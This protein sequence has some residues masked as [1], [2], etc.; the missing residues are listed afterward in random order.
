MMLYPGAPSRWQFTF[1]MLY[2]HAAKLLRLVSAAAILASPILPGGTMWSL[3]SL[4]L[5]AL[6]IVMS[7]FFGLW[8][9]REEDK[10]PYVSAPRP[11]RDCRTTLAETRFIRFHQ[12]ERRC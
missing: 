1:A 3:S 8:N 12:L 11:Y 2:L 10:V 6:C 4:S 7:L 5:Y 9:M